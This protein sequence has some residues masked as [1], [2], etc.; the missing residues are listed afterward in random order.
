MSFPCY[1]VTSN[2]VQHYVQQYLGPINAQ[3]TQEARDA[4]F[5]GDASGI[6][7]LMKQAQ[8]EFDQHLIPA[9]HRQTMIEFRI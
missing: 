6:G 8:Q 2:E 7:A 5:R 9:S 3:I 4:L 1:P